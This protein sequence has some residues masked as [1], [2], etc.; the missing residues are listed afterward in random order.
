MLDGDPPYFTIN[1]PPLLLRHDGFV[2]ELS[3][4]IASTNISPRQICLEITE[5]GFMRDAAAMTAA[6]KRCAI[7]ACA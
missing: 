6:A 3:A 7:A 2:A 4:Q 1:I 5:S